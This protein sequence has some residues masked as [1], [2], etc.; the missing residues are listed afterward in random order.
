MSDF[1][2]WQTD[3]FV[4]V[5]P[6]YVLLLALIYAQYP[7][8]LRLTK[9]KLG[10]GEVLASIL[11]ALLIG[12]VIHQASTFAL[13]VVQ[14]LAA[15]PTF[16]AIARDFDEEPLVRQRLARRLAAPLQDGGDSY[17]Y[18][19]ALIAKE[20]PSIAD[21]N[22]RL[23]RLANVCQNMV[24]ALVLASAVIGVSPHVRATKLRYRAMGGGSRR[25]TRRRSVRLRNDQVLDGCSFS[26]S[27]Y[28]SATAQLTNLV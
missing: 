1:G 9:E 20:A 17:L 26:H 14:Q 4:Y 27:A 19:R 8:R 16:E 13:S 22:E 23:L 10:V 15:W 28:S 21:A 6:G 24:L 3:V 11:A 12:V 7:D 2:L 5:V 18:A 25:G